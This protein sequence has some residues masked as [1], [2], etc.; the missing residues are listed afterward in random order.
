MIG[1]TAYGGYV[2]YNRL[3]FKTIA[4]EY[5]KK[6]EEGERA[7]AYYDEDSITMAVAASL[8][9]IVPGYAKH[10]DAVYFATTTS[11]YAE[12]QGQLILLRHLMQGTIF[13]PVTLEIAS[14]K[15]NCN[16]DSNCRCQV[17]T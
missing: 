11:P 8:A 9:G 13:V 7:V 2:P 4:G 17:R 1:I 6:A 5:D 14:R 16:A 10:L 3:Q 15:L 12:K